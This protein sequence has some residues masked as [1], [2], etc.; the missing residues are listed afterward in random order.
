ME[1]E[2]DLDKKAKT[3]H[4]NPLP[5][6]GPF[7][8]ARSNKP[9]TEIQ[10]FQS[11]LDMRMEDRKAY[12]A[13]AQ[14]KQQEEEMARLEQEAQRKVMTIVLR[15][16]SNALNRLETKKRLNAFER[17]S[18]TRPNQLTNMLRYI[19]NHLIKS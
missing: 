1:K 4:A 15:L 13:E 11:H 9:L 3:F 18:L 17:K 2:Q 7:V 8:P 5:E 14:E 16:H 12:E 19:S 10:P 6:A